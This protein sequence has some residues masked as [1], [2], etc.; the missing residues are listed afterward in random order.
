MRRHVRVDVRENAKTTIA[1]DGVEQDRIERFI[2]QQHAGDHVA[3]LDLVRLVTPAE[4]RERGIA[5]GDADVPRLV[6]TLSGSEYDIEIDG[7]ADLIEMF[8]NEARKA[9]EQQRMAVGSFVIHEPGEPGGPLPTLAELLRDAKRYRALREYTTREG[10]VAFASENGAVWTVDDDGRVD[11]EMTLDRVADEMR[12]HF[13]RLAARRAA[14][15]TDTS[16]GPER[17]S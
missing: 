3:R 1:I 5:F 12:E 2:M 10:T 8:E 9:A 13:G 11:N 7:I 15:D 4:A 16:H 14:A 17:T 6:D